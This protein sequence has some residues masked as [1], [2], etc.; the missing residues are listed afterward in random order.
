MAVPTFYVG[1]RPTTPLVV[2]VRNDDGTV[3]DLTSYGSVE[4]VGDELPSGTASIANAVQGKVQY[5]F[6]AEF[7]TAE[8]LTVQVKMIAG[9]AAD[10]SSPITISVLDVADAG[11]LLVTAVQ[12][13]ATTNV[14]V[15]QSDVVRAQNLV[16]LVVGRDL[17][18]AEWYSD[19]WSSDQFWLKGA[20]SWEAADLR[21][22]AN[23]GSFQMPYVPGASSISNGDVSVSF[24]SSDEAANGVIGANAAMAIRRL[25]W[26]Q[27]MRSI[28][29]KPFIGE[30]GRPS[31]WEPMYRTSM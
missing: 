21:E 10:Y 3:K 26:M 24:S 6:N 11:T 12:V 20:V 1:E 9:S 18:D 31:V 28:Q 29:A 8:S 25:S 27:P 15:T 16:S 5:D 22:K 17:G 23:A 2:T 19:L 13:E 14:S 30:C 7:T 4:L